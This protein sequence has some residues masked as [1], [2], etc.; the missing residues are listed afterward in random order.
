MKYFLIA[1]EA[2]GDL[3]GSSLMEGILEKDP[4]ATFAFWGG[5]LMAARAPGLK[6]H[7]RENSIMGFAEVVLNLS[8]IKRNMNLCRQQIKAFAPDV[9][10]L[11]DYPGFNLRMAA[12][13]HSLGIKTCYFIAPKIWAWNEK[14]GYKLEK[15]VNKLLLIFPFEA[16]YFK[17]WKLPSVYVGNP[18]YQQ[19]QQYKVV[20]QLQATDKRP[21]IALLPGSRKQEIKRMLPL[22]IEMAEAYPGHRFIIGGAPGLDPSFYNPWLKPNVEILFG[23]T[24]DV[25][26]HAQAAIVCSGTASLETAFFG[27]P[28]VVGYVAQ[29]IS[30][31]L[32]R[33]LVKVKYASLVNLSMDREVVKELLQYDYTFEKL[34]AELDAILPGGPKRSLQLK[35]YEALS[36]LYES[37]PAAQLA[38]QEIADLI[39]A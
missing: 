36:F 14:R 18:M 17:K 25:L 3:L 30:Y 1:G 2:S 13:A 28:Q 10:V 6:M 31:Y 11:I 15:Y 37:K 24:R 20:Q 35:D 34:K 39:K 33:W 32:A 12:Y 19:I 9:L 27:V 4:Q 16:E 8:K 29:P 21:I 23:A 38:A 7:Y 5:D 26:A 22:M